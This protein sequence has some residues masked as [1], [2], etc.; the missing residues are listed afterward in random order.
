MVKD[1]LRRDLKAVRDLIPVPDRAAYSTGLVEMIRSM[2]EYSD[3]SVILLYC[4]IGSEPDL[5]PLAEYAERESKTVAFPVTH[6]GEM[7]FCVKDS[8]SGFRPGAMGIP[9]PTG[10]ELVCA[11]KKAD[12]LCVVPAL[13][14]D[15]CGYR[16]GYGGGYYDRFLSGF[17]GR[18]VCAVYPQLFVDSLPV[19]KHDEPVD[20]AAVAGD[21]ITRFR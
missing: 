9:E 17:A 5:M 16:I 15:K 3:A 1:L 19:E 14:V 13:A 21:G 20:A 8:S 2:P 10:E 18:S 6:F 12:V 11:A 7:T 4:P